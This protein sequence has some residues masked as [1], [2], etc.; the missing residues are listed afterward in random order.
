MPFTGPGYVR[1][2]I[3]IQWTGDYFVGTFSD[4]GDKQTRFRFNTHDRSIQTSDMGIPV[5]FEQV[6]TMVHEDAN[7]YWVMYEQ[8]RH[9]LGQ[10]TFSPS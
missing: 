2:L 1:S 4:N 10:T 8:Y 3:D 5:S 6:R 9:L 7:S